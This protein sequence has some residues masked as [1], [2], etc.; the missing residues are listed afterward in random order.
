MFECWDTV[1][2][3]V[4]NYKTDRLKAKHQQRSEAR[5]SIREQRKQAKA[6]PQKKTSQQAKPEPASPKQLEA[7]AQHRTEAITAQRQRDTRT[8]QTLSSQH[9]HRL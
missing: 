9:K 8:T 7:E 5:Q 3:E 1:I 6:T 2:Y 4:L